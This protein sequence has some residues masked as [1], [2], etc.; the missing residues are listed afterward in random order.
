[1]E[2]HQGHLL[3]LTNLTPTQQQAVA[4][5]STQQ[6]VQEPPNSS[7]ADY[8][9]YTMPVA[10]CQAGSSS[11]QHW[12]LL[13]A[14]RPGSAVTDMDV[15]AGAVVL[16]TLLDSRP[17][18]L[19]LT[20]AE[21]GSSMGGALAVGQQYQVSSARPVTAGLQTAAK[22]Q[23]QPR[24]GH[25]AVRLSV[26][27]HNARGVQTTCWAH[28]DSS[29]Y[30]M[31]PRC[32]LQVQ[33]PDW[34][35]WLRPG[36]NGAYS[37]TSFRL[38][39][40]SPAHAEVALQL[41]LSAG[42]LAH[43]QGECHTP[44][45]CSTQHQQHQQHQQQ[46]R[47]GRASSTQPPDCGLVSQRLWATAADGTAVPLTL[48]RKA[49]LPLTA[50][51]PLLVEVYG[52]YGHVLESDFKPHRL[53]L[54]DRGWSVALAHVRGG[55]ELGRRWATH[56][57]CLAAVS[58]WLGLCQRPPHLTAS[59]ARQERKVVQCEC[60]QAPS[61]GLP[62]AALCRWHA[63][64]RQLLKHHSVTDLL[65]VL[66]HCVDLRVT[67]PGLITGHAAS[68]GALTLAA[69]INAQPELF[70]A[71]VLEAP[72]V[73]WVAGTGAVTQAGEPLV[74]EHL[75]TQHETDEWG[76][77]WADPAA[78]EVITALCPYTNLRP[79]VQYPAILLTAGLADSRV[80]WWMPVKYAAKMRMQDR[81]SR[82]SSSSHHGGHAGGGVVGGN[83]WADVLLQFDET[84]SHFSMGLSGGD[85][86]DAALQ[87]AFLLSHTQMG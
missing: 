21:E 31:M 42:T 28:Q 86:Q 5:N 3:L 67:A 62:C 16:H 6:Q 63:A 15:F 23:Q 14:E 39:V 81:G 57:A 80:P 55:G 56:L 13:N 79:G 61:V 43:V 36:V 18:L 59:T 76:D 24:T 44:A 34:A 73:D 52:A 78:A 64:G 37:S 27:P 20:L 60:C 54:L 22:V 11:L 2:H 29:G 75:L 69:A 87:Q 49:G 33:L 47:Q 38:Y 58:S 71:A 50:P 19:V 41:D 65:A 70:S 8:S 4:T 66:Q 10:G 77:P 17:S 46:H 83:R 82:S 9:L 53:P 1:M 30:I 68:A 26:P 48:L 35:L 51:R 72:F 32:V 40:S 7:A 84:G 85:L 45:A 12:Q 74:G 25:R